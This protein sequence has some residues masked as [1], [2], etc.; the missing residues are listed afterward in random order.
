MASINNS[1]RGADYLS[2]IELLVIDQMEALTMQNWE[3]VKVCCSLV[4]IV[5][6]SHIASLL[7]PIS[8]KFP[9]SLMTQTFRG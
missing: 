6:T 1:F 5:P 2:S 8:T 9:K 7:C 3:H 4:K